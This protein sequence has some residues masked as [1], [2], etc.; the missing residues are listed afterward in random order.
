MYQYSGMNY[1]CG[2]SYLCMF[3]ELWNGWETVWKKDNG[4]VMVWV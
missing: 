4:T 1:I 3:I 2:V